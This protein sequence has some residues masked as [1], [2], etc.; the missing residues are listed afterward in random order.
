MPREPGSA[1]RR[2]V[3]DVASLGI[4]AGFAWTLACLVL[5]DGSGLPVLHIVLLWLG[6]TGAVGGLTALALREKAG[7]PYSQPRR[8]NQR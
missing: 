6:G 5:T 1:G 4:V 7:P 3:A 2:R 8:R